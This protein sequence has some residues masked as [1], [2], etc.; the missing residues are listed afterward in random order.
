MTQPTRTLLKPLPKK[1]PTP[2]QAVGEGGNPQTTSIK[3]I[4]L[5]HIPGRYRRISVPPALHRLVAL[6]RQT[7]HQISAKNLLRS[8]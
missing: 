1:K 8:P 6:Q 4:W 5:K 2:K 7:H 3:G